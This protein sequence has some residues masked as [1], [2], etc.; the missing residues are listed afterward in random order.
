MIF[1][2]LGKINV[3]VD[4]PSK[5]EVT[6][7]DNNDGT[8]SITYVPPSPGEYKIAIKAGDRHIRGSPFS[9]KITGKR[10]MTKCLFWLSS[11]LLNYIWLNFLFIVFILTVNIVI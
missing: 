1:I 9:A 4:G 5:T 8:M 6:C 3:S 11:I 10:E 2:I 7:H